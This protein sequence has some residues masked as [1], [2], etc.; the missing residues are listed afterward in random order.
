MAN[1]W[2]AAQSSLPLFGVTSWYTPPPPTHTHRAKTWPQ[3]ARAQLCLGRGVGGGSGQ[4]HP[5]HSFPPSCLRLG[6]GPHA[7]FQFTN[8]VIL[9]MGMLGCI[10][11]L[12]NGPYVLDNGPHLLGIMLH[13]GLRHIWDYSGLCPIQ[14]YVVRYFVVWHYIAFRVMSF[15]IM[16]LCR[17]RTYVVWDY[18]IRR[19]VIRCNVIWPN[20]IRP[21]VGVSHLLLSFYQ[22]IFNIFIN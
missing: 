12:G 13:S 2:C 11:G 18:V 8:R 16:A 5:S 21:T 1:I 9:I 22:S 3:V 7:C 20:V 15:G 19:N 14:G 4:L 17:I 6:N 10:L